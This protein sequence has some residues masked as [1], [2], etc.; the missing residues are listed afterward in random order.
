MRKGIKVIVLFML[1]IFC[2][3]GCSAMGKAWDHLTICPYPFLHPAEDIVDI[4]IGITHNSDSETGEFLVEEAKRLETIA[5]IPPEQWETLLERFS[6]I[7]CREIRITDPGELQNEETV[8]YIA[9]RNGDFELIDSHAQGTYKANAFRIKRFEDYG[10][11]YSRTSY[12]TLDSVAFDALIRQTL[13]EL[14][15][16]E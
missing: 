15:E 10:Q 12:Y 5:T 6:A 4:R 8:I 3:S 13:E 1:V 7:E 11:H 9:Y 2:L 14:E 16:A